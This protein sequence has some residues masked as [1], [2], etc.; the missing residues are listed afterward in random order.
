MSKRKIEKEAMIN[1]IQAFCSG[2]K[3]RTEITEELGIG[4][5]TFTKWV[6][7]YEKYGADYLEP[8]KGNASYPKEFKLMVVLEY[9]S[10]K[11]SYDSLC[12]KYNISHQSVVQRWVREYNE[13]K[14]FKDYDPKQGIYLMKSRKVS[15]EE[16]ID[17]VE[18]CLN[19]FYNY[20][21]SAEKFA[22]PYGQVYQ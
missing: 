8:K 19:N 16:K 10:G 3:S 20:K 15:K 4:R 11:G 2:L 1:A 18:F 17:I 13:G 7:V 6:S 12:I 22:V 21:L 14:E 5:T 9:L